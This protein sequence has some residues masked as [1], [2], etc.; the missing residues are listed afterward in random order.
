MQKAAFFFSKEN[1][2][3]T[4]FKS[5]HCVA[6]ASYYCKAARIAF[7]K[8]TVKLYKVSYDFVPVA[9]QA[10]AYVVQVAALTILALPEL[11]NIS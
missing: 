3:S 9:L 5:P 11:A 1:C 6:E 7:A 2:F 8:K 10:L 4:S